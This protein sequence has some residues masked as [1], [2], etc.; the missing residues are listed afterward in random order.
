MRGA[1]SMTLVRSRLAAG[2]APLLLAACTSSPQPRGGAAAE[3]APPPAPVATSD[4]GP[5][6]GTPPRYVEAHVPGA[7]RSMR[8]IEKALREYAHD[9]A[10]R[11]PATL[12]D[13]SREKNVDGDPYLRAVPND[14]WGR[15]YSYAVLV[16][17][18]G[19]YDLRSYGPDG[20]PATA[21][22]VVSRAGSVPID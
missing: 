17:R 18:A 3:G 5:E 20:L 10:G 7:F 19:R 1:L 8:A 16:A 14:P 2:L 13:L 15:P 22:D 11:L 6:A 12:S 4:A 21:D 9:H